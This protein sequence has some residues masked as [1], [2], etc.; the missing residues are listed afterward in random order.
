LDDWK[1]YQKEIAYWSDEYHRNDEVRNPVIP[2][3]V[4]NDSYDRKDTH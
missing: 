3:E 2:V 1:L 4:Q